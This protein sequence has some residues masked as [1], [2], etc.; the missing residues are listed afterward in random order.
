MHIARGNEVTSH[1]VL[2]VEPRRQRGSCGVKSCFIRPRPFLQV[3]VSVPAAMAAEFGNPRM[4][5]YLE[6]YKWT[7]EAAI[8]E[9]ATPLPP[10]L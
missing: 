9:R 3:R 1:V 10:P 7:G 8:N 4:A 6:S 2:E 5:Y